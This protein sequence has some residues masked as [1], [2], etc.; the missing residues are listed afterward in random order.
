M[1]VSNLIR[2]AGL[3]LTLPIPLWNDALNKAVRGAH[4][5]IGADA[6]DPTTTYPRGAFRGLGFSMHE[7]DSGNILHFMLVIAVAGWLL[8]PRAAGR[9]DWREYG[10]VLAAGALVFVCLLK[11]QPWHSRLHLG[12]FV[13]AAPLA[14]AVLDDRLGRRA[15][16]AVTTLLL[17]AAIPWLLWN[18]PRPLAGGEG[19]LVADRAAQYFANGPKLMEPYRR[20][21]DYVRARGHDRVGLMLGGNDWEYPLW[22]LLGQES[23]Q[24]SI[25]LE[26]LGVEN[27]THA[28]E[29]SRPPFRPAVVIST[30]PT[31]PEVDYGGA[32]YER[33]ASWSPVTVYEEV[34]VP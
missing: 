26:H 33:R 32:R 1:I 10:L 9:G 20:A 23:G 5:A 12:L 22:V 18:R 29:A 25:R 31:R 17:V 11:W 34:P 8:T 6:N 16:R 19:V 13:L 27:A 14:A 24:R 2:N 21:A 4:H 30:T 28:F 7:D 3:H 15:V